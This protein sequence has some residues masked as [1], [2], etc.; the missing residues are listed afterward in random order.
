MSEQMSRIDWPA[1]Y[2]RTDPED[3]EPYDGDLSPTRKESFKSI[4]DELERWGA[5]SIDIETASDHYVDRPNIP[6]QHDK[7]DDVG[8]VVRFRHEDEA[9]D[10]P[11][12]Y[13]CDHWETQR[14][15]ARAIALYVRR[16]RLAEKCQIATGQSTAATARLP[17]GD[18]DDDV[19]VAGTSEPELD[20]E[21]AAELLG[22]APDAPDR[23]VETA[24]Q[25]AIKDG[26]P[27]Q[28]GDASMSR[29]KEAR[30]VLT[31]AG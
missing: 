23:V 11:L 25:E 1:G 29:L 19:I 18:E 21:R 28:G 12:A 27:D 20:V 6:H 3:R 31:D 30:E 15:N 7:P 14:E 24:F 9:A 8:V 26:H 16:M 10:E 5:T 2:D 13:A 17:G 4:V 22:V